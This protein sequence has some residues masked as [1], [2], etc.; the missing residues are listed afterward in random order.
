MTR[1]YATFVPDSEHPA[2]SVDARKRHPQGRV[3]L[4]VN[5]H[6]LDVSGVY[7]RAKLTKDRATFTN[8]AREVSQTSGGGTLVG[9]NHFIASIFFDD[10]PPG[11]Y[12]AEI[13][14]DDEW[15]LTGKLTV[16]SEPKRL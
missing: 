11:E 6:S 14:M 3:E 4:H 13:G 15:M 1:N 16:M 5:R 9:K 12:Y 2:I 8:G 7:I 10:L